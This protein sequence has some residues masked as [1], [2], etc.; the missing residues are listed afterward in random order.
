M[1]GK[2]GDVPELCAVNANMIRITPTTTPCSVFVQFNDGSNLKIVNKST[3]MHG[4]ADE[5]PQ[6]G[7]RYSFCTQSCSV[8]SLSNQ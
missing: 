8:A 7:I 5:E 6:R 3:F 4:E 1:R 2:N